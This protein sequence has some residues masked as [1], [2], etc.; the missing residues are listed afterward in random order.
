MVGNILGVYFPQ[1]TLGRKEAIFGDANSKPDSVINTMLLLGKQFIW[2]RKFGS[3]SLDELSFIIYMKNEL[4][5]LYQTMVFKG[6]KIKFRREWD[7][8]LEHFEI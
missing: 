5:F 2:R 1:F 8:I 6:K 4:N 3:K 7:V